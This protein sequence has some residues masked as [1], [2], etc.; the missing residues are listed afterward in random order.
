MLINELAG[1]ILLATFSMAAYI[2]LRDAFA[3]NNEVYHWRR[4]LL[5][6]GLLAAMQLFAIWSEQSKLQAIGW[7]IVAFITAD[8]MVMCQHFFEVIL[9]KRPVSYPTRPLLVFG[10]LFIV[11]AA[12]SVCFPPKI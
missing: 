12:W 10:G 9:G 6:I 7:A 1:Y 4:W 5:L 8:S 2:V 11:L 3:R